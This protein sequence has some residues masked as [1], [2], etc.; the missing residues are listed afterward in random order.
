MDNRAVSPV[1]G[2]LLASGLAVLYIASITGLLVGGIVPDYRAAT[3]DELGERVLATAAGHVE[4]AQPTTA[5]SADVRTEVALP[6]T[7]RDQQYQIRL[8]NGTLVLDH[9]DDALDARTQLALPSNVTAANSTW[10]SGDRLVI[11]T[12]GPSSNRTV[13]LQEGER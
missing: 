6:A 4:R 12:T 1:V 7:I 13:T 3:G 2:K 9:P 5:G 8:A 11:R 10:D